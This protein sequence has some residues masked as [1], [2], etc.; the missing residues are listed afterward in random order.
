MSRERTLIIIVVL[1][2]G[3][4]FAGRA[5]ERNSAPDSSSEL[6]EAASTAAPTTPADPAQEQPQTSPPDYKFTHPTRGPDAARV[7]IVEV[8]D[9]ECPFCG[10]GRETLDQLKSEFSQDVRTIFINL[11]LSF[12]EH[13]LPAAIAAFAAHKQ[14][15]FWPFYEQ[16]FMSSKALSASKIKTIAQQLQLNM[17][18]FE[19]D[20]QDDV[21]KQRVLDDTAIA[22]RLGITA[23]PAYFV[24]GVQVSGA[25]PLDKFKAI[26]A[27]QLKVADEL[28]RD[29]VPRQKLHGRLWRRN[30]PAKADAVMD[31][32]IR[33]GR[34]PQ[35]AR[36]KPPKRPK[37]KTK[38]PAA[39]PKHPAKDKTIW[40]VDLTGKEPSQGADRPLLTAVLFTDFQCPYCV[41]V[42]PTLKQLEKTY[43]DRLR[44]VFKNQPLSFHKKAPMAAEAALCVHQQGLFWQMEQRLFE[45]QSE[46]DPAQLE[47]HAVAIKADR[48]RYRRCMKDRATQ[49]ML[50]ADQ[51]AAGLVNV[52]GTPTLFINGRRISGSQPFSIYVQVIDQEL[53]RAQ[54]ALDAGVDRSK[55]YEHLIKEGKQN[56]RPEV[57]AAKAA[58][59][60]L[61][62]ATSLKGNNEKLSIVTFVDFQCPYCA[63]F[64]PRLLALKRVMKVPVSLHIKHLPLSSQCNRTMARDLHPGACIVANWV[65]ATSSQNK[66][67]AFASGVLKDP[68]T[69]SVG[70]P[71]R[72]KT[73]LKA[74]AQ[75]VGIN[76]QRVEKALGDGS[77][78]A[79]VAAHI[80]E[81][82]RLGLRG[83]PSV[84]FNGREYRGSLQVDAMLQAVDKV[85]AGAGKAP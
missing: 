51:M 48:N 8:S 79:I 63:R 76:L 39:K 32:I 68:K 62:G 5:L 16:L 67:W 44:L 66:G 9:F 2:A 26:V 84:L 69:F 46:L 27:E 13:A 64:L 25:Q 21:L 54:A 38:K 53:K 11:P 81:S 19:A 20:I 24:N 6:I 82:A 61:E 56:K 43:P 45:R 47:E 23:T 29:G 42:R 30:N 33:D 3:A 12:H 73:N 7:T 75:K 14:G 77:A 83:T 17:G 15:K 35:S 70:D 57:L 58:N 22:A 36:P 10:R 49:K 72:L 80:E 1:L 40:K 60:A 50:Q 85:L 41:R 34:P 37:A 78:A 74:L 4:F 18:Q 65:A 55:L 52:T 59:V 31:W 71:E 28:L